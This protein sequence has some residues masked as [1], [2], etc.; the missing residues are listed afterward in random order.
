MLRHQLDERTRQRADI[1]RAERL[2]E[3]E[4]SRPERAFLAGQR[5]RQ[6]RLVDG[7]DAL[8]R[9][10][11]ADPEQLAQV[12]LVRGALAEVLAKRPRDDVRRQVRRELQP[13]VRALRA[14]AAPRL[15]QVARVRE[16]RELGVAREQLEDHLVVYRR[17]HAE[18]TQVRDEVIA[19]VAIE[20][21][22]GSPALAP[23]VVD[24]L[25]VPV[26]VRRVRARLVREHEPAI[27][28][29][30]RDRQRREHRG[31]RLRRE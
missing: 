13:H 24:R 6:A 1:D 21:L 27:P 4:H 3:R 30:E 8:E 15:A 9:R 26:E 20:Q 18:V 22:L 2:A 14:L 23:L 16:R 17:E 29:C 25:A 7:A 11:P 10:V 31:R 5:V 12:A 19:H 28:A